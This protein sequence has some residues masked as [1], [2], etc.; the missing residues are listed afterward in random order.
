VTDVVGEA[1]SVPA[2]TAWMQERTDLTPPLRFAAIPGGRSNLTFRVDVA[3]GRHWILRRPPLH[4]VLASAHDVGRE[5]RI[6]HALRTTDVPVPAMVGHE[7][8]TT[9]IGAPFFVMSFVEGVAPRSTRDVTDLID[10]AGRQR[11]GLGLASTLAAIHAVPIEAVGLGDLAR[12]ENYVARQLRRWSAQHRDTADPVPGVAAIHDLLVARIP[13]QREATL[14][15]GDFRLDNTIIGP[16]GHIRAVLDWELCTLGDPLADLG[17]FAAY[18][19]PPAGS[20]IPGI[21][22]A[23]D[24]PDMP[25]FAEVCDYYATSSGRDITDLDYYTAF[26]CWKIA[27]IFYG[28]AERLKAGAYGTKRGTHEPFAGM[29]PDLLE[30]AAQLLSTAVKA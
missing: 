2:I 12:R 4:S 24:I 15:H 10:R 18:W 23:A 16:D 20:P 19:Q 6:M 14:T 21:P 13:P 17:L 5:H 27:V 7:E 9:A 26:G 3:A 29:A 22:A 30:R 1:I 25:N 11:V 28:V 8:S